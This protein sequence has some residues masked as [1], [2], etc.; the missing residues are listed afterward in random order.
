[1]ELLARK[2]HEIERQNAALRA[3][4]RTAKRKIRALEREI[5][6]SERSERVILDQTELELLGR[7]SE[8]DVD[9][10]FPVEFAADMALAP[11]GLDYHLQR[12][13]DGGYVELLFT[14]SALGDNFG[15]TQRG[16]HA[17]IRRR[18]L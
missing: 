2:T 7:I 9:N 15:V 18:L 8:C 12:L 14:D 16:R 13:V 17:L 6:R 11:A 4:L 1:M 10:G 5:G 3:Q